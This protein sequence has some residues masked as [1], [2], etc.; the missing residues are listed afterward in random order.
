MKIYVAS[1][2]RN[3]LQPGIVSILRNAGHEVYDFRNPAIDNTGFAWAQI[4]PAWRSWTPRAYR[5][6]LQHPIAQTGFKFDIDALNAC[7]ACLLVLP[8]GRSASF[9]Y[10]YA[11]AQ[12]KQCA[13]LMLDAYEP[14]LM[15]SG[16]DILVSM[17]ELFDWAGVPK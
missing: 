16:T 5:Q 13:V 14:E 12:G 11:V 2:W 7:E 1:S 10:G 3:L 4:D 17:D 15:Y 6:A 8:S 9:E